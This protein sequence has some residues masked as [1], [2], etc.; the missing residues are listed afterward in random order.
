MHAIIALDLNVLNSLY[1]IR[2]VPL[3]LFFMGVSMF[4]QWEVVVGIVM[5]IS[6]AAVFHKRYADVAGLLVATLG[7]GGFILL[8][9]YSI[10]RPRPELFYQA[11]IEGPYYSF[12][13]AHAGLS[14]A[15]YGFC[16][17]LLVQSASTQLRRFLI[18]MLPILIFLI[19]LSRLYLGV[20][21]LSDVIAGFAV[22]ALFV[23]F[24][25][26]TRL[27]LLKWDSPRG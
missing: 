4:G 12:P 8:L 17:Y 20:H 19:G 21:Y 26:Q 3:T 7:S 27:R 11:Y 15:F 9:K 14:L 24:G 1:S 22:G 13:S 25:I 23:W 16:M 18:T 2:S 6:V 5:A 10:Q